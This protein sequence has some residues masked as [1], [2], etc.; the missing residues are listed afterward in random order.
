M[1]RTALAL[2]DANMKHGQ[3]SAP[4]G[5]L[6]PVVDTN[7]IYVREAYKDLYDTIL[8]TFENNTPYTGNELKK[9]V[10]VTGTSGI[11]KSAFLVYFAIRLL[12]ESDDDN[13]PIIVF[14]TKRSAKC[15]VFGGRSTVRSGNIEAFKPFLSLPDTWYFVDSTPD[16]VLGRAKT[17]ISASPKTLFSEAHQYQDVDKRVAWRYYM[18][19]WSLEE[20]KKCRI[21]VVGFEVVPLEAV[22]ELY[23]KIGGVP[24][25]VL[26]R[27]MQNLSLRPNDLER[28]KV[29]ACERLE[30]ALD[31]VKDPVMLMQYFSQGRDTLDF[32]SRLIH[33]WPMDDHDTFR[34]EWASTY[35][36]E[37]SG[38]LKKLV[39]DPN[40]SASGIMFEAYVLRTFRE[41]GHIFE[42]KDLETG[43]SARLEIPRNPE[44][45][46]AYQR[47]AT[48]PVSICCSPP[49][50]IPITV[51]KNHPIKGLPLSKL[52]DNLIQ[53]RWI[54]P[55]DEPRLIFVVPGH[56][57]ADF[58][59]QDYLTSEGKVY[60][61]VPADI[62]RVRQ[63][64]LKIDLESAAGGKSPG[65]QIPVQQNAGTK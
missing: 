23:S 28:A 35:V 3:V 47:F 65:L 25:Y 12:A 59:K 1:S 48:M 8:G 6:L 62:Q 38:M 63:Y 36:A 37:K 22:E 39:M 7:D 30:Q 41:G 49:E 20:L 64:V 5:I 4:R 14:H 34:L 9:H 60:R 52:I 13:P 40:G 43:Q 45:H 54:L 27:P 18:A 15:Y 21:S 57:Y 46:Y 44:A 33:R 29:M 50:T 42:L 17:V 53:A 58:E 11:G 10:I 51:S 24:R 19:P 55:H 26:E 16:P 32:S 2:H 31:R 56:V 61:T